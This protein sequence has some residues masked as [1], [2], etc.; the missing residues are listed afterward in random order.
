MKYAT[1]NAGQYGC[2]NGDLQKGFKPMGKVPSDLD[3]SQPS[4]ES[5]TNDKV[6]SSVPNTGEI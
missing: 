5:K 4:T 1:D 3:R 2:G 6:K